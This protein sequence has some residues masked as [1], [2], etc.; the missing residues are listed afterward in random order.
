[1]TSPD[2]NASTKSYCLC[3]ILDWCL[4][5]PQFFENCI[6]EVLTNNGEQIN[7]NQVLLSQIEPYW[8]GQDVLSAGHHTANATMNILHERFEGV[9][10]ARTDDVNWLLRLC[11]LAPLNLFWWDFLKFQIYAN[12][13]QSADQNPRIQATLP[14]NEANAAVL[15]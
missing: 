4:I 9:V 5:G 14:N 15:F 11:D 13:A 1:M 10:I 12:N 7:D 6:R 8:R 3:R 2:S